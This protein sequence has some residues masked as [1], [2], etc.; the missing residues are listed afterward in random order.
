VTDLSIYPKKIKLK[1][2]KQLAIRPMET[3]DEA[4]VLH[5]LQGI[6]LEHRLFL[7]DDV[8]DEKTVKNWVKSLNYEKIIPLLGEA[9]RKVVANGTLHFST[10]RWMKHVG[11]IRILVDPKYRGLGIGRAIIH[12]LF[13]LGISAGME[14][15]MATQ[16]DS[17]EFLVS[18][19]VSLGFFEVARIPKHVKD[20]K[21]IKHDLVFLV[22][23]AK[24]VW[25]QQERMMQDE[26]FF[27]L[28]G[29]Y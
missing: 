27:P 10:L 12:E 2:R 7:R 16:M 18:V 25:E 20:M 29:Q 17:E 23:E 26:Q 24:D 19:L 11:E 21:G 1:S 13:G 8:A 15:I 4:K 14:R 9:D 5:F 22:A 28:S 6:P 3:K